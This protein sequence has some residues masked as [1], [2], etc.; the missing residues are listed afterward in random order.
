MKAELIKALS[1]EQVE[2]AHAAY[3]ALAVIY[4]SVCD[5]PR[6]ARAYREY[7]GI[8]DTRENLRKRYIELSRS[9]YGNE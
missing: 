6:N 1:I 2:K 3:T 8:M 5:G 4:E 7:F 9:V